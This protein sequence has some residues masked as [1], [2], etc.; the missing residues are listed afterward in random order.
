MTGWASSAAHPWSSAGGERRAEGAGYG[1]R[2]SRQ[3]CQL[4]GEAQPGSAEHTFVHSRAHTAQKVDQLPRMNPS[5][6]PTRRQRYTMHR[7]LVLAATFVTALL[8]AA[9]GADASG[10]A[11]TTPSSTA[12]MSDPLTQSDFCKAGG[13]LAT[14]LTA[15][16]NSTDTTGETV[17]KLN[18][19]QSELQTAI[20]DAQTLQPG[21]TKFATEATN[22]ATAVG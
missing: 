1:C 7:S 21:D 10:S 6:Q 2:A 12:A 19:V 11:G 3:G 20:A 13:D 8:I 9:C 17:G 5:D 16:S 4:R 22:L 18:T 14:A 15:L